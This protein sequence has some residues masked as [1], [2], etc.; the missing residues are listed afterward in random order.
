MAGEEGDEPRDEEQ[1]PAAPESGS[2][3]AAAIAAVLHN[4]QPGVQYD[5]QQATPL[6]LVEH[7]ELQHLNDPEVQAQVQA[8]QHAAHQN[9]TPQITNQDISEAVPAPGSVAHAVAVSNAALWIEVVYGPKIVVEQQHITFTGLSLEQHAE[10][11]AHYRLMGLI[12]E[13]EKTE[14]LQNSLTSKLYSS[15]FV[16]RV[17][18]A[19]VRAKTTCST[20]GT[21]TRLYSLGSEVVLSG[22]LEIGQYLEPLT[23]VLLMCRRSDYSYR[24]PCLGVKGV[25][26]NT[27]RFIATA[28]GLE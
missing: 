5:G 15:T 10:K 27:R 12:T 24:H 7:A 1:A 25:L 20:Y 19:A 11:E 26:L 16:F 13:A 22:A 28:L 2:N 21:V 4:L 9:F 23:S 8:V 6:G 17:F 14:W 18:L 3:Q